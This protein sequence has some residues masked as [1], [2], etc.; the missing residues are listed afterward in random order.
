MTFLLLADQL[1]LKVNK[2]AFVN[3]D[4]S[5][6]KTCYSVTFSVSGSLVANGNKTDTSTALKALLHPL[7]VFV[8]VKS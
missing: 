4:A 5:G 6:V 7:S 3:C 1:K 8:L 2:L